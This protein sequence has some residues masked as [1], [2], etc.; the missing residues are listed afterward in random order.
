MNSRS[1]DEEVGDSRRQDQL[2]CTVKDG[3]LNSSETRG[4]DK[5]VGIELGY[6]VDWI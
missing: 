3:W 2:S 1:G 6:G 4:G 5:I